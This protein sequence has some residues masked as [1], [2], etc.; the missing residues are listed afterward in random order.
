MKSNSPLIILAIGVAVV[1][2]LLVVY[3]RRSPLEKTGDSIREAGRDLKDA[4]DPRS[5][6]KKMS[7]GIKETVNDIKN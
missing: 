5:P 4:V 2:L 6:A 1:I 3:E 7:D